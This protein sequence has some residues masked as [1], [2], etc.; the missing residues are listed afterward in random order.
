MTE[1]SERKRITQAVEKSNKKLIISHVGGADFLLP[2]EMGIIMGMYQ[3]DT[4]TRGVSVID[5]NSWHF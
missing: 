2:Y 1:D 5:F 3:C 4:T